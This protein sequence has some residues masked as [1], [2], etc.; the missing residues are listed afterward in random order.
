MAAP[1]RSGPSAVQDMLWDRAD[2]E[3]V[4]VLSEKRGLGLAVSV[5]EK[6][7]GRLARAMDFGGFDLTVV[8]DADAC[9]ATIT[10]TKPDIVFLDERVVAYTPE[11]QDRV[12]R[13]RVTESLP[14]L[15]VYQG[16][17]DETGALALTTQSADGEIFLKTR[18]VLRRERPVA[19]TNNRQ[20]GA[21]ILDEP[22]FKLHF[23]GKS[24]D[25]SKTELCLIGPFFDVQ[26]GLLDRQSIEHLALADRG[27][28]LA[29]RVVDFKVSRMRRRLKRQLGIDPLRSVRGIGYALADT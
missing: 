6:L 22:R 28:D 20:R 21:L 11:F 7:T 19:L 17:Y 25:L 16:R 14:I 9:L 1:T 27:H 23:K 24:A 12:L 10:R 3:P 2:L 18:A 8:A 4:R 29:N 15:P 26:N 13:A 5:C